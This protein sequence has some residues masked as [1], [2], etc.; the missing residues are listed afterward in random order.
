MIVT[1]AVPK[2]A[3]ALAFSV[4][5]LLPLVLAGLNVAVTPFG[6]PV[7]DKLT[8]P[9]NPFNLFTVIVLVTLLPRPTLKVLGAAD[10]LKSGAGAEA[11]TVRLTMVVCVRLPEVPVTVTVTVPTVATLLAA[12]VNVLFPVVGFGLNPADT[13]LGKAEVTA[14][15]TLP[16]NPFAGVTVIVVFPP[17]PPC[18]IINEFG[19]ALRLKS[20]T[21]G[22]A[23]TV[24]LTDVV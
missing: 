16:L 18:T 11:L 3:G 17:A 4:S 2:F 1:V 24:R 20:G 15:P 22:A 12:N 14:R 23:L 5:V 10:K 9:L 19:E 6:K 21:G 13:P 8:A 7:A